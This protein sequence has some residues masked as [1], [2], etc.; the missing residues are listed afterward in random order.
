MTTPPLSVNLL[1]R[2]LFEKEIEV[3]TILKFFAS[4]RAGRDRG[5]PM[6]FDDDDN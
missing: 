4:C 3:S 1:P 5:I 6:I 2:G